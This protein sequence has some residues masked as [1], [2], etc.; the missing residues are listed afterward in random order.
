MTRWLSPRRNGSSAVLAGLG[1]AYLV[2]LVI[3]LVTAPAGAP[4]T[5]PWFTL[6]EGLILLIAPLMVAMMAAIHARAATEARTGALLAVAFMAVA[7]ALT[8]TV[9]FSILIL[10]R[11]PPFTDAVWSSVFAFEWPS[12]VYAVDILAW[13]GFFPLALFCAAPAVRSG[14]IRR[15]LLLAAAL[16]LIGL[17]GPVLGRMDIRN[18]GILGYAVVFPV[19]AALYAFRGPAPAQSSD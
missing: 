15:L 11:T 3:G 13:D 14:L 17:L 16:A 2:V 6:M 1:A 7:A 5:D 12:V 18:I 19:A 8:A 4:I 10:S 9:H